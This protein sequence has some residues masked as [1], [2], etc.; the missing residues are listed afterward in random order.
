[1]NQIK[2]DP[3]WTRYYLSES[4]SNVLLQQL[5]M[6]LGKNELHEA[7]VKCG[8]S[9]MT[10]AME[11]NPSLKADFEAIEDEK[12]DQEAF[13]VGVI[14]FLHGYILDRIRDSI[15]KSQ[16]EI[17]GHENFE[18]ESEAQILLSIVYLFIKPSSLISPKIIV[19]ARKAALSTFRKY[20]GSAG[21][22]EAQFVGPDLIFQ[23]SLGEIVLNDLQLKEL[24]ES[25]M[26]PVFIK[27]EI[28]PG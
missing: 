14:M 6:E 26:G 5:E 23:Q 7:I 15:I 4:Q 3:V 10:R 22:E 19:N 8:Y 17:Y 24:V 12:R 28:Y 27:D 25:R 20:V 11:I 18:N 16:R 21:V 9:Q 1:M 13:D 2:I